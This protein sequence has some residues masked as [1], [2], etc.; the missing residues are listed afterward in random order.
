MPKHIP[1]IVISLALIVVLAACG[2]GGPSNTITV[3]LTDFQ[4]IPNNFTIPAGEEITLRAT[5]TGAVVHDFVIM[6]YGTTVGDNYAD[7]DKPN[8]YWMVELQPGETTSTTFDAP[9][10]PGEYQVICG[11]KGHFAAGMIAKMTVVARE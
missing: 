5:N 8:I 2:A 1:L 6:K 7:E 9:A 4:F 3:T 11:I 10:D